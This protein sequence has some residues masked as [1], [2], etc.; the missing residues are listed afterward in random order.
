MAGVRK[1]AGFN[2]RKVENIST[3]F[4]NVDFIFAE[5]E[6]DVALHVAHHD[7]PITVSVKGNVSGQSKINKTTYM[8]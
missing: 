3:V 5:V 6:V 8:I 7:F 4:G 2:W 1:T